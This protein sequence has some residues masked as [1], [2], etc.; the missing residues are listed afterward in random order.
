[1]R[2]SDWRNLIAEAYDKGKFEIVEVMRPA[3]SQLGFIVIK[4]MG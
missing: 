3:G 1:M 4:W 2:G